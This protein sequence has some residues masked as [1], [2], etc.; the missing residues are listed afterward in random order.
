M[1]QEDLDYQ[2]DNEHSD[3]MTQPYSR[4]RDAIKL[5][6]IDGSFGEEKSQSIRDNRGV[7]KLRSFGEDLKRYFP[8]LN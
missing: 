4:E 7:D 3:S 8:K 2:R 1:E 5:I 6:S